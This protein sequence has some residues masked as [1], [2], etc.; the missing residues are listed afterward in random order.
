[1]SAA[2]AV[3]ATTAAAAARAGLS[4]SAAL[5]PV[6]TRR[7]GNAGT[8]RRDVRSAV[9]AGASVDEQQRS[10]GGSF[11]ALVRDERRVG[12]VDVRRSGVSAAACE[13]RLESGSLSSLLRRNELDS[14]AAARTVLIDHAA[15]WRRRPLLLVLFTTKAF[16]IIAL[17][18]LKT[19]A[20]Q[21]N[22]SRSP[23]SRWRTL[24]AKSCLK[25]GLQ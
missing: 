14:P 9:F 18:E 11:G 17:F 8:A 22:N 3:C 19:S 24:R 1:L 2:A 12:D 15:K 4:A 6:E 5:L 10:G 20:D 7:G 23:P 25:C 21:H 16:I 13:V